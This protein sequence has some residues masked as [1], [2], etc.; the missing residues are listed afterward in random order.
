MYHNEYSRQL[1]LDLDF[2]S[3]K[4]NVE[5]ILNFDIKI[6]EE[7]FNKFFNYKLNVNQNIIQKFNLNL[8]LFSWL[9]SE[10][11]FNTSCHGYIQSK[12]NVF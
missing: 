3:F 9:P 8:P 6:Y 2:K 7:V 10:H 11:Y 1:S 4:I 12:G 5:E